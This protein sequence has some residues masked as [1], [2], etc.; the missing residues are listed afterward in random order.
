MK[1]S[2]QFA[3][4]NCRSARR[5]VVLDYVFVNN[6]EIKGYEVD[7]SD[8]STG[9]EMFNVEADTVS[10]SDNDED[11]IADD[12]SA[13]PESNDP[14]LAA[15]SNTTPRLKVPVEH[16]PIETATRKKCRMCQ[17]KKDKKNIRSS[18]STWDSM[19][20]IWYL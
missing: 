14:P 3:I 13:P 18:V 1:F 15:P 9:N 20:Q 10:G 2:N 7:E 6:F 19:Y 11:I 4:L 16:Y 8:G 12:D 5:V 17:M